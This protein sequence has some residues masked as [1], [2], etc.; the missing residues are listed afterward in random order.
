MDENKTVAKLTEG[1]VAL[2]F[3]I[4]AL[5]FAL[6]WFEWI[7]L[8]IEFGAVSK[9]ELTLSKELFV[10]GSIVFFLVIVVVTRYIGD[11]PP[12]VEKEN[13]ERDKDEYLFL[14]T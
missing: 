5:T 4:L 11:L 13:E 6:V 1:I 7:R 3:V 9:E 14:Y 8:G 10:S 2:T 12:S